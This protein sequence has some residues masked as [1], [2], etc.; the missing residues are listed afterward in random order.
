MVERPK[1]P[2]MAPSRGVSPSVILLAAGLEKQIGAQTLGREEFAT[3]IINRKP[4]NLRLHNAVLSDFTQKKQ[5][6]YWDSDSRPFA[7]QVAVWRGTVVSAIENTASES[8][9]LNSV[10]LSMFGVTDSDWNRVKGDSEGRKEFLARK[11]EEFREGFFSDKPDIHGFAEYFTQRE[12]RS[13][14]E[15]IQDLDELGGFL[16]IFGGKEGAQLVTDTVLAHAYLTHIQDESQRNNLLDYA[17]LVLAKEMP[18]EIA[19]LYKGLYPE[20]PEE[21]KREAALTRRGAEEADKS[22][23]SPEQWRQWLKATKAD[24]QVF[25]HIYSVRDELERGY[26]TAEG[27]KEIKSLARQELSSL[28]NDAISM[29]YERFAPFIKALPS[30]HGEGHFAR[31]LVNFTTLMA[32]PQA[33][34]LYGDE[35]EVA[36]GVFAGLFHDIGNSVVKRYDDA[37]RSAGHAEVGAYLFGEIAKDILPPNVLKLTQ[38]AI[39]AHTHYPKDA[40][41]PDANGK[42][43]RAYAGRDSIVEDE[44]GRHRLAIWLTRQFDRRDLLEDVPILIRHMETKAV[45]TRD[46][47]EGGHHE[48]EADELLDFQFQFKPIAGKKDGE[49]FQAI[50][51]NS[52]SMTSV[53]DVKGTPNVLAHVLGLSQSAFAQNMYTQYDSEYFRDLA[54]EANKGIVDFIRAVEAEGPTMSAEARV[55][56][57]DNFYKMCRIIDPGRDLDSDVIRLFKEKFATMPQEDLSHWAQGF[58]LLSTDLWKN[59]FERISSTIGATLPDDIT[60]NKNVDILIADVQRRANKV[61]GAFNPD[62]L[63]VEIDKLPQISELIK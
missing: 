60:G 26:E 43:K 5:H 53:K 20:N 55:S 10:V 2:E 44:E 28:P 18:G 37:I 23:W 3:N 50:D 57:F 59:W 31:D 41:K 29:L 48:P 46:Y 62:L 38:Y 9:D 52:S 63:D 36:V 56:A 19:A 34:Q 61:M 24:V 40:D 58:S 27:W 17:Q 35:V 16:T 45:P 22:Q 21:E 13:W 15:T 42:M 12:K 39:A 54:L 47:A 14:S 6:E 32:D 30:G 51:M 4:D 1:I 7:E 8:G 49:E 25:D 11:V 33:K